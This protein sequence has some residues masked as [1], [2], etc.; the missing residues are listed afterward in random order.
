MPNSVS[1]TT[2][3]EYYSRWQVVS[4]PKGKKWLCQCDCGRQRVSY[5]SQLV[6]GNVS[7]CSYYRDICR[8]E[9]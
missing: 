9:M 1:P 3:E 6:S 8:L 5:R 7:N 4:K 2:N